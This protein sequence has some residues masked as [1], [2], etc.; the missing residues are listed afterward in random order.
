[1]SNPRRFPESSTSGAEAYAEKDGLPAEV[2]RLKSAFKGMTLRAN[3]KIT[4]D[5]V[6][7]MVVHPERTKTLVMAGDKQGVLGMY[8]DNPFWRGIR[9]SLR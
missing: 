4:T 1:M 9:L 7:S 2:E 3:A 5:R 8:V 6:F